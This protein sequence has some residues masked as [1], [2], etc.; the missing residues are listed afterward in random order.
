MQGV[1]SSG[2]S[3]PAPVGSEEISGCCWELAGSSEPTMPVEPSYGAIVMEDGQRDEFLAKPAG[4]NENNQSGVFR[5]AND[6][7]DQPVA[8][9]DP[10]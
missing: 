10:G 9:E 1:K 7:L 6:L 5:Q 2:F 4:T 8:S 3:I